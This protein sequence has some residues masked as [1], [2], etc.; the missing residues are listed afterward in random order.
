[1]ASAATPLPIVFV[2]AMPSP[3][4]RWMPSTMATPA[5][6]IWLVAASV[7]ASTTSAAPATPAAPFDVSI[8]MA[9]S[10]T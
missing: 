8:R 1:M 10:V 5:T 2:T 7:P 4:K 3:M 9:S 6:G